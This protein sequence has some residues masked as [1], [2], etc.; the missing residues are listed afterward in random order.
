MRSLIVVVSVHHGNTRKVASALSEVL[1]SVV[2]E[3]EEVSLEEF[4]SCDLVGFGSGIYFGKFHKRLLDFVRNLPPLGGKKAFVFSTS[5]LGRESYNRPL[6]ELLTRRGFV[7]LGSFACRGF[8]TFGPLK[9][10]GG[11]NRGRP[12]KKDLEN[13]VRFAREIQTYL[14]RDKDA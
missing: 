4:S 8:D 11:I 6:E 5:G 10:F 3:P 13:A 2:K 1:G 9:L 12:G 14:G 7:V